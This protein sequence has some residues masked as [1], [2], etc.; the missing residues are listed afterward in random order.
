M[1]ALYSK[2]RWLDETEQ[3]VAE[4]RGLLP[5]TRLQRYIPEYFMEWEEE[6]RALERRRREKGGQEV[7]ELLERGFG[8][9]RERENYEQ[10][11]E[12]WYGYVSSLVTGESLLEDDDG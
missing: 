8:A 4:L 1:V 11:W 9:G 3:A 10:A 6:A 5:P 2:R 12:D 7:S